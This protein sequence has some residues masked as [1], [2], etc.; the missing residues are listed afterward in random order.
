MNICSDKHDEVVYEGGLC[1]MC[2][3]I[4]DHEG[5]MRDKE[6]LEQQVETLTDEL[7]EAKSEQT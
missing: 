5:L 6:E 2:D 3:L 1:P 7:E 4:E